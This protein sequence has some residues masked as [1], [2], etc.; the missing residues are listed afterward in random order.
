[1]EFFGIPSRASTGYK[2]HHAVIQPHTAYRGQ[3]DDQ[4]KAE[5]KQ[6]RLGGAKLPGNHN[7]HHEGED[8]CHHFDS[9]TERATE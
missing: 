8:C 5:I 3:Q 9:Q 7:I 1:M 6:P 4:R 2:P